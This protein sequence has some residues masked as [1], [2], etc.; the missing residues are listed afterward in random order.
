MLLTA[1]FLLHYHNLRNFSSQL[2]L[3]LRP[4]CLLMFYINELVKVYYF[5]P[6]RE[7]S[8]TLVVLILS[9]DV[10]VM[11]SYLS[12]NILKVYQETPF[13]TKTSVINEVFH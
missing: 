10:D 12:D 13:F 1:H 11:I 2:I 9:N 4:P 3:C 8:V 7:F 5:S 6:L